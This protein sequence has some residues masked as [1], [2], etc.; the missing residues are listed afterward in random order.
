MPNDHFLPHIVNPNRLPMPRANDRSPKTMA[1]LLRTVVHAPGIARH[2]LACHANNTEHAW[3]CEETSDMLVR[4]WHHDLR[5]PKR[6][7]LGY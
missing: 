1:G 5:E 2:M 6:A 3:C 4:G 7:D